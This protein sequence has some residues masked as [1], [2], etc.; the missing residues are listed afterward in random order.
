MEEWTRP[1]PIP[2]IE[3]ECATWF[4][5]ICSSRHKMEIALSSSETTQHCG[6][7]YSATRSSERYE[8]SVARSLSI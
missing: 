6:E 8:P 4:I 7:G 2:D 3:I 1:H 5:Q